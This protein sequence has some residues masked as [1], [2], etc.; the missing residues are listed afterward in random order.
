MLK[1]TVLR[2]SKKPHNHAVVK[3]I[4]IGYVELVES[5]GKGIANAN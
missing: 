1:I 3:N 4:E 2:I 5:I